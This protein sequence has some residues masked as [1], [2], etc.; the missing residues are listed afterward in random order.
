MTAPDP[1]DID[2]DA[3]RTARPAGAARRGR[4]P[5]PRT[6]PSPDAPPMR[7]GRHVATAQ[8]RQAVA[9]SQGPAEDDRQFVLALARGLDVLAA[10]K[11]KDAPLGNR[12]LAE[13][14]GMPSATVSR[15]THT[16]TQ[17]GY[18]H[19]DPRHET[20]DLGGSSVALGHMALARLSV[21]RVALGPMQRLAQQ[22][23]ANVGLGV[24]ERLSMLYAETCEGAGPVG[25]RL[26]A[27]SRIPMATSAMGRAW[28][29]ALGPADRDAVLAELAPQ[30]GG[31]WPAV[32]RGIEQARRDVAR[33]G[34]CCSLGEWQQDI[35]G[36]AVPL[37]EPASGRIYAINLGGPAYM[38]PRKAML[39]QHGPRLV[40]VRNEILGRLGALR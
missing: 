37:V 20:Y 21:R 5:L 24:R 29:A 40:A 9:D 23:N 6:P 4:P 8:A 36:A 30:H 14:T 25:L 3:T 17:L 7:R 18:L 12:E 28:L 16:L 32:L 33:Q 34:F 2:D 13:R 22:A 15:L 31:D 10:F 1:P 26:H 19:F 11:A 38:L 35:H 39:E 27:G